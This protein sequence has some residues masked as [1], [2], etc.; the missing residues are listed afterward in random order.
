MMS[1]NVFT[2]IFLLLNQCKGIQVL[3]ISEKKKEERNLEIIELSITKSTIS[4]VVTE[5]EDAL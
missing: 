2:K 4:V 1:V 3:S 5:N